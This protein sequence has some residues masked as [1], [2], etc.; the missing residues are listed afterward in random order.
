LIVS[1]LHCKTKHRKS[2]SKK[3]AVKFSS[4]ESGSWRKM[5]H[6]FVSQF[7]YDH[8][9]SVLTY[10]CKIHWETKE[11]MKMVNSNGSWNN[12]HNNFNLFKIF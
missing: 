5:H 7:K 1:V 8:E 11:S 9:L 6:A 10:F 4:T 2:G 3:T 12:W